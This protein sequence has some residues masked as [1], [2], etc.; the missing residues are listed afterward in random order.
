MISKK[1]KA[2]SSII[3]MIII[4]TAVPIHIA[5][6]KV[7]RSESRIHEQRL[8]FSSKA[9]TG[10]IKVVFPGGNRLGA[11]YAAAMPLGKEKNLI[12]Y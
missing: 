8:N 9:F 12:Q 4:I 2:I 5:C 3:A 1:L 6:A 7:M 10:E 11:T